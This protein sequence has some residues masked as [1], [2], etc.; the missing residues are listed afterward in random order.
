MHV[1]LLLDASER[2]EIV[3]NKSIYSIIFK[4]SPY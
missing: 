3:G 2:D 1:I 4:E